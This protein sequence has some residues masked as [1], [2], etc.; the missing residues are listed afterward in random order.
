MWPPVRSDRAGGAFFPDARRATMHRLVDRA[1][2]QPAVR[3]PSARKPRVSQ[4]FTQPAQKVVMTV[5]LSQSRLLSR[6]DSDA[7]A[8]RRPLC[9]PFRGCQITENERSA[10]ALAL[11][12]SRKVSGIENREN[13]PFALTTHL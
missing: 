11:W 9:G 5:A 3:R 13:S 1:R 6:S 2:P 7:G 12:G 8:W 10:S 4:G